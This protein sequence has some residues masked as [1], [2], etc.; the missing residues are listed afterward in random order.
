M[1]NINN[2]ILKLNKGTRREKRGNEDTVRDW[3]YKLLK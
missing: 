1:F 3:P 2:E